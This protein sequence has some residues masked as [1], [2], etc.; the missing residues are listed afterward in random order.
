MFLNNENFSTFSLALYEFLTVRNRIMTHIVIR[1]KRQCSYNYIWGSYTQT[2]IFPKYTCASLPLPCIFHILT[3]I[4][5][6]H[7][8]RYTHVT[9][10]C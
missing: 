10:I 3:Y 8:R 5:L 2:L 4:S 7:V 6:M 9:V 1:F